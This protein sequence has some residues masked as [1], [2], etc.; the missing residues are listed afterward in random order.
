MI[1]SQH[2][3]CTRAY[4]SCWLAHESTTQSGDS[5]RLDSI[6]GES[7]MSTLK[8]PEV[9]SKASLDARVPGV[10]VC[11][12]PGSAKKPWIAN[13]GRGCEGSVKVSGT[14]PGVRWL[15]KVRMARMYCTNKVSISGAVVGDPRVLPLDGDTVVYW[16]AVVDVG[17]AP[18]PGLDDARLSGGRSLSRPHIPTALVVDVV[19]AVREMPA[20]E[21]ISAV[22]NGGGV[23][24]PDSW[25]CPICRRFSTHTQDHASIGRSKMPRC[26]MLVWKP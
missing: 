4:K 23:Q 25:L 3:R 9:Q 7:I 16:Y 20:L 12:G 2:V 6:R 5:V 1:K 22:K 26:Q 15:C 13:P 8:R 14:G 11:T 24:R 10:V 18:Q 17:A 19:C 21:P